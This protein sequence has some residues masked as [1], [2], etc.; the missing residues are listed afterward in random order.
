ML[1][2]TV[3][4]RAELLA[5][6]LK[7]LQAELGDY[8]MVICTAL[9]FLNMVLLNVLEFSVIWRMGVS[10]VRWTMNTVVDFSSSFLSSCQLLM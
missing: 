6:E 9:P 3:C 2:I 4:H 8:N 7:E 1:C 10:E 5:Q